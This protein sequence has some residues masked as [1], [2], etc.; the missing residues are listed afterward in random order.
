MAKFHRLILAVLFGVFASC[1]I[2]FFSTDLY[3][4]A[5]LANVPD[6]SKGLVHKLDIGHGFVRYGSETQF[7]VLMASKNC[8]PISGFIFLLGIVLGLKWKLI[9]LRR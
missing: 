3:Y 9:H 7:R 4:A 1:V 2:F 5:A 6:K 8:I